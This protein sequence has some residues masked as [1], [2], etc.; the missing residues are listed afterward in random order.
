MEG[1]G[2]EFGGFYSGRNVIISRFPQILIPGG[3]HTGEE[4]DRIAKSGGTE[5]WGREEGGGRRTEL[6]MK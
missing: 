5:L 2:A 6:G 4:G 3:L 1:N